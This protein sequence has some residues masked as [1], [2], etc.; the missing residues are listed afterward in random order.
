ME[1]Q[2]QAPRTP[3]ER[4]VAIDVI[5]G[6]ALLGILIMNIQ[7]FS[8]IFAAYSN[9]TAYGDLTGVNY[10]VYYFSHIFANQKFMTIFSLLFGCSIM[11]MAD[12]IIKKGGS[13]GKTH[14]KR[15]FILAMFGIAHAYL[16]WFGDILLPYAIAGMIAYTARNLSVKKLMIVGFIL[17]SITSLMMWAYG[18]LLPDLEAKDIEAM[19]VMWAPSAEA[20]QQNLSSNLSSWIGQMDTRHLMASKMHTNLFFYLFRIVGLMMVGMALYKMD[21]FGKRFTNKTLWISGAVSIIIAVVAIDIELTENF[22]QNWQFEQMFL[23]TQFNYW[24]S[25]LMAYGYMCLL[26]I[27]ARSTILASVKGALANVGRM[28]LSNYLM[29]TIICGF[30]FYGWGLGYYGSFERIEQLGVVVGIWVFQ[31]FFSTFWMNRFRFGP[32]EWLWRTLT[33]GQMPQLKKSAVTA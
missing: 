16:L 4:I 5:R 33:Y 1:F 18:I 15:M 20:V 11:L 8:M 32:F 7:A 28:A 14:Y 30:I 24:G 6:V 22:V 25:I 17:I 9:P 10:Y 26:M 27:F 21:F 12:N 23:G 29:H 2:T 3:K 31:L 19:K 13:P